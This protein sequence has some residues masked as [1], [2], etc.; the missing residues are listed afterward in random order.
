MAEIKKESKLNNPI[1]FIQS[2]ENG[3][4]LMGNNIG[5]KYALTKDDFEYVYY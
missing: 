2:G 1:I 5:I 4:F 3:G